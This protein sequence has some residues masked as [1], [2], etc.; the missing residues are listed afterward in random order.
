MTDD[1]AI[2]LA[3]AKGLTLAGF[4]EVVVGSLGDVEL[5]DLLDAKNAP[6]PTTFEIALV[7]D[8]GTEARIAAA[9]A[10]GRALG[11]RLLRGLALVDRN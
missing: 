8:L 7:P 3:L 9:R 2:G 1:R 6:E 11:T 5:V 4:D 10:Y